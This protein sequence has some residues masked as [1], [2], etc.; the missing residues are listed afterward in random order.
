[1]TSADL[2][3]YD[4]EWGNFLPQTAIAPA[5]LGQHEQQAQSFVVAQAALR[6]TDRSLEPA[7]DRTAR[8]AAKS[9]RRRLDRLTPRRR[10]PRVDPMA[11]FCVAMAL[12]C[13]AGFVLGMAM[14]HRESILQAH[15][16]SADSKLHGGQA[17]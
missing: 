11:V 3:Y 14:L 8:L 13:I 4:H 12:L 17:R 9:Q 10:A 16:V 2:T 1:M 6:P 15:G 7:T 5:S